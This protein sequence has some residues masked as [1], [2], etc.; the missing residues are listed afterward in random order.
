MQSRFRLCTVLMLILACCFSVSKTIQGISNSSS[1]GFQIPH[2]GY[3]I[4]DLTCQPDKCKTAIHVPD[5]ERE[6]VITTFRGA[7]LIIYVE[8]YDFTSETGTALVSKHT[9][10]LVEAAYETQI[11][12]KGLKDPSR[13]SFQVSPKDGNSPVLATY[14]MHDLATRQLNSQIPVKRSDPVTLGTYLETLSAIR[15]V[16]EI[17]DDSQKP[18]K[19][20]FTATP[21]PVL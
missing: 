6:M 10:G 3:R 12:F 16:I 13:I 18:Q 14:E 4:S 9:K 8:W 11:W 17:D 15:V 1:P 19:I 2:S 5:T 21:L 20:E 7:E